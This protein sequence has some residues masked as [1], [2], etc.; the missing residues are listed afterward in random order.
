MSVTHKLMNFPT[1]GCLSCS[2]LV[3]PSIEALSFANDRSA[4]C[5]S[6]HAATGGRI[7]ESGVATFDCPRVH[8]TP[9]KAL[10]TTVLLPDQPRGSSRIV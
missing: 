7:T 3:A 8:E 4:L 2:R 9:A 6:P 1:S 10:A 5:I